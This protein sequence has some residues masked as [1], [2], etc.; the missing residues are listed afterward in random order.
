MHGTLALA[1]EP[2]VTMTNQMVGANLCDYDNQNS[3]ADTTYVIG[4][5]YQHSSECAVLLNY[6]LGPLYYWADKVTR[7]EYVAVPVAV[8][9][10]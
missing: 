1:D 5:P 7:T 9:M 6:F 3:K 2:F 4:G 10:S 8:G